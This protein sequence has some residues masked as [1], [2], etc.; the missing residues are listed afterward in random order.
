MV[1]N[2]YTPQDDSTIRALAGTRTAAEIGQL[3][4]PRRTAS[5][6]YARAHKLR[7]SLDRRAGAWSDQEIAFLVQ[8]AEKGQSAEQIAQGLPK[9]TQ[10]AVI[11]EA[12]RRGLSLRRAPVFDAREQLWFRAPTGKEA[13]LAAMLNELADAFPHA[14]T[15]GSVIYEAIRYAYEQVEAAADY[16]H[17]RTRYE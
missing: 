6:V 16:R 15:K 4:S 1:R 7:V 11:S 8:Q 3:L 13:S 17:D 14:D 12:K 10:S 9:R 5:S 2:P